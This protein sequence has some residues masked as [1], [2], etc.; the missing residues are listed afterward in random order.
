M[1]GAVAVYGEK[2]TTNS[3]AAAIYTWD[4]SGMSTTR[5]TE[6]KVINSKAYGSIH[7]RLSLLR[8]QLHNS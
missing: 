7:V 2:S 4:A 3:V 8:Q 1:G 5:V 6:N